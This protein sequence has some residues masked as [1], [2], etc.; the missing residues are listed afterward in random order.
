MH[1]V[2]EDSF[3]V[4]PI[5]EGDTITKNGLPAYVHVEGENVLGTPM[6]NRDIGGFG[7]CTPTSDLIA[8]VT[9]YHTN[10]DGGN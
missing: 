2:C 4:T 8:E 5:D 10:H 7:G 1:L 6:Y 9:V 3:I